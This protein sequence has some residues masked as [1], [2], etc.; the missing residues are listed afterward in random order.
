MQNDLSGD[1]PYVQGVCPAGWHVPSQVEWA[2]LISNLGAPENAGGKLKSTGSVEAQNGLWHS[3]NL[4]ADNSSGFN[5]LPGSYH[6]SVNFG[7]PGWT[8]YWWSST[9]ASGESAY[10]IRLNYET[11]E[12]RQTGLNMASGFSVR[13]I[14][15]PE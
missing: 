14:E 13:C 12:A 3:P 9:I 7:I 5:G 2:E 11:T 8:G 15:N 4:G 10:A 6:E 1:K